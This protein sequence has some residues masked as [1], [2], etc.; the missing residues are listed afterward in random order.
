MNKAS[1]MASSMALMRDMS[2]I[3]QAINR[4]REIGRSV[5]LSAINA[6]LA[7]R[8]V[9]SAALGFS[10]AAQELRVFSKRLNIQTGVLSGGIGE[11]VRVTARMVMETRQEMLLRQALRLSGN[12]G[13]AKRVAAQGE[14]VGA[15]QLKLERYLDSLEKTLRVVQLM[16]LQGIGFTRAARVE[17]AYAGTHR[18][19]LTTVAEEMEKSVS[20]ILALNRSA[21]KQLGVWK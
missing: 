5:D 19:R 9:G 12:G 10:V 8:G 7:A 6:G 13:M 17:A 11:V 1:V 14:C 21:R 20:E 16:G 4:I 3:Q 18:S 2:R 15:G